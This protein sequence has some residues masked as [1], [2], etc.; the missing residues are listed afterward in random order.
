MT[1]PG[2]GGYTATHH[3]AQLMRQSASI[4]QQN[5]LHRRSAVFN[6]VVPPTAPKT[7]SL[8]LQITKTFTIHES[9]PVEGSV[10]QYELLI[11]DQL[12]W[13]GMGDDR[14]DALLEAIMRIADQ[15]PDIPNN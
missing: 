7:T 4:V 5:M 15:E 6:V 11:D 13:S 10:R 9:E 8:G 3:A 2:S 1:T 14:A 12:V